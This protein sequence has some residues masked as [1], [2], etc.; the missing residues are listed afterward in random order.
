MPH[1]NLKFKMSLVGFESGTL[2]L[3]GQHCTLQVVS[4][5]MNVKKLMS[6]DFLDIILEN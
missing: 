2:V 5:Q 1:E 4:V 6:K 3:Q